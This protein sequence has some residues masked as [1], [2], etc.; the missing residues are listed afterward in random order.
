MAE[1][2]DIVVAG[3]GHNGLT[4]AAYLARAG[5][6]VCVVE[7]Q[8]IVGGTVATREL[9]L[10]G[11][12][13]EVG[14]YMHGVIQANPLIRK[15]ELKLKSKYGLKYIY[16]EKVFEAVFPDGR[17]MCFY[18]DLDKTCQ[19]IA[20][21]SARDA[22]AYRAFFAASNTLLK[23]ASVAMFSPVPKWGS[24]MAFLDASEEGR[25]FIRTIMSSAA[26]IADEWFDNDE[27]KV[28]VTRFAS[29]MMV[30]PYDRGTGNAMFFVSS[31]H[32]GGY[33]LV[34]GGSGELSNSLAACIRDNGGT[35]RTSSTVQRIRSA[36]GEATG[37]VLETGEEILAGKAVVSNLNIKQLAS[38]MIDAGQLH[39]NF[40]DKVKRIKHST[41]SA[42]NIALA[43]GQA[44]V[45]K[46]GNKCDAMFTE[47]SPFMEEYVHM[48][49][50]YNHGI[51][52]YAMPLV[53]VPT[54]FDP[55]RAPGGQHTVYIYHYEPYLLR[56]GGAGLWDEIRQETANRIIKAAAEH[57]DG[58]D[59]ANVLGMNIISPLDIERYNPAMPTGDI[60]HI[61]SFLNQS[62]GNRPLPG[63]GQYRTPLKRLYMC[64][65]G[66]HPGGGVT[67]GGRAAALLIM[68]DMGIDYRKVTER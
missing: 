13:H 53:A 47:I 57:I 11:F 67:G 18:R 4:V 26:E 3:G 51:T 14:A 42:M 8:D 32:L 23:I 2:H 61:G 12:K 54:V 56:H 27:V 55:S 28:A 9:T 37:V 35:I 50:E 17:T 49:E 29:E 36:G 10:P 60:L 16:P 52:N 39:A 64:G 45:F 30:S 34:E 68:E 20:G 15:D 7:R 1:K 65:A 5:L 46:N 41:F 24:M 21:F 66:T 6:N 38:G 59:G 19:S 62:Y 33:G 25:E 40:I 48:F 22:D 58:L 43:T 44:P 31:L 63:W